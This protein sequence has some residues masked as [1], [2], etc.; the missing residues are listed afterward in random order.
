[1]VAFRACRTA[2]PS[3]PH[4]HPHAHA[5]GQPHWPGRLTGVLLAVLLALLGGS[6]SPG[7]AAATPANAGSTASSSA[8]SVPGEHNTSGEGC[9]SG[10]EEHPHLRATLTHPPLIAHQGGTPL[11]PTGQQQE[12]QAW[13]G[14]LLPPQPGISAAHLTHHSPRHGRAPPP[15][16]DI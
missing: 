8:C 5:H 2:S 16:T 3:H 1:M 9:A 10:T 14:S 6:A 4:A 11:L 13:T 15:R 7:N 12:D